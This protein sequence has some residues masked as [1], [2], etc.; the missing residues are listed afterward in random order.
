[1]VHPVKV[2]DVHVKQYILKSIRYIT[3]NMQLTMHAVHRFEIR[4][5]VRKRKVY[6]CGPIAVNKTAYKYIT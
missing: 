4:C 2:H 3:G 6:M 5:D 1:M